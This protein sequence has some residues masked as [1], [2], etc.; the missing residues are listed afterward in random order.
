MKNVGIHNSSKNAT[1]FVTSTVSFCFTC[2]IC[3]GRV[4]RPSI[5]NFCLS[6]SWFC[7]F[8][9]PYYRVYVLPLSLS[10]SLLL[11]RE[12]C[13]CVASVLFRSLLCIYLKFFFVV[14]GCCYCNKTKK[15]SHENN[16]A[17]NSSSLS[18]SSY[19]DDDCE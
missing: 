16:I 4:L 3:F 13:K 11:E 18:S 19:H 14:V 10:L 17:Y 8:V 6:C 1:R 7:Y 9:E 15:F 5:A 2:A 12:L